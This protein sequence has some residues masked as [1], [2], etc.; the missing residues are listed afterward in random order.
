M[1]RE[2]RN[3]IRKIDTLVLGYCCIAFFTK[4][5][6]VSAINYSF[7]SGMD[8]DLDLYSDCLNY[9]TLSTR[10]VG[11]CASQILSN[12]LIARLFALGTAFV[13]TYNQLLALHF[14]V[15]FDATACHV[16][17]L[18]IVNCWYKLAELGHRH[19]I[20]FCAMPLGN[21]AAGYLQA[22]PLKLNYHHGFPGKELA[23]NRLR[24]DNFEE[25]KGLRKELLFRVAQTWQF[26]QFMFIGNLF[27]VAPCT[28]KTPFLLWLD[29]L[30][31]YSTTEV[32]NLS[33]CTAATAVIAALLSAVY[34]DWH[35]NRWEMTLLA[36]ALMLA[37]NVM[38]LVWNLS[39]PAL[40]LAFLFQGV[41]NG[42]RNLS[43][44]IL[45][46]INASNCILWLVVTLG[47]WQ[48]KDAPRYFAHFLT[49]VAMSAVLVCFI[50]VAVYFQHR[51][52]RWFNER[53]C[54]L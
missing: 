34:S 53:G 22:G 26:W 41:A 17:C 19:A 1:S 11:Y 31:A 45:T 18:H 15:G 21:M 36:A 8:D 47:A 52:E 40:F 7:V 2:E 9:R 6:D 42:A 46:S 24:D 4:Y 37:G 27:W 54:C 32:N 12:I 49:S 20:Y 28:S 25:S 5:L 10:L 14:F 39:R 51:D 29:D 16:G 48:T 33:T 38:L 43:A 35:R 44:V 50:P 3:L 30:G 13:N 23:F